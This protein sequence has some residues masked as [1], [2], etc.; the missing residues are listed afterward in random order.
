MTALVTVCARMEFANARI[1]DG[2][3][4]LV[5]KWFVR[6]IVLAVDNATMALVA[7]SMDS[8]VL[9]APCEYAPMNA[10]TTANACLMEP[11]RATMAG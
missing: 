10:T 2:L 8:G 6:A 4:L 7:V 9:T 11:V 1:L 3:V 5:M